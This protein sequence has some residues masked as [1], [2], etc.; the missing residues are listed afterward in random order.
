M[1]RR[2]HPIFTLLF[3]VA[4]AIL[5]TVCSNV[6]AQAKVKVTIKN[7]ICTVSGKGPMMKTKSYNQ[8]I[9]KVIIQKG[10]TSIPVEAFCGCQNLSEVSIAN[11]VTSIGATAFAETNLREIT[12]PNSV[13]KLGI[14]VVGLCKKLKKMKMPGNVKPTYGCDDFYS[15]LQFTLGSPVKTIEL[16]TNLNLDIFMFLA[17]ENIVV[18]KKD[19]SFASVDGLLYSK[20]KK[21]LVRIPSLRKNAVIA[22]G[23]EEFCT[24]A[25]EWAGDIDGDPFMGCEK[26]KSVTLPES[27]C[28]IDTQKYKTSKGTCPFNEDNDKKEFISFTI[29]NKNMTWEQIFLLH[30]K[31][32]TPY[33]ELYNDVPN[34]FESG[35][36]ETQHTGSAYTRSKKTRK[37]YTISF[38]IL[39]LEAADGYELQLSTNKNFTKKVTKKVVAKQEKNVVCKHI[40]LSNTLYLYSRVRPYQ[41]IDGN[42]IY[43]NW[44]YEKYDAHIF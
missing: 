26:L 35:N 10:V 2:K 42:K 25:I 40:N 16:T 37:G 27:I 23:C 41:I 18:S 13:K 36:I 29:E 38:R 19:P 24:N 14:S 5:A 31:F 30:N 11:S 28:T 22:D 17:A 44:T 12:I 34:A 32:N 20:D 33:E 8:K 7:G 43:G 39:Q 3:V 15:T 4:A 6:S 9:K 21:S 1:K